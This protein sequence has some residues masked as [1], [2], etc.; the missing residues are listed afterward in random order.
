MNDLNF[1]LE[2]E[3]LEARIAKMTPEQLKAFDE[4]TAEYN[5]LPWLPQPGPQIDAFE[6]EADEMLYGGAAGGGKTDLIVGLSLTAHERTVV[7]R[8]QST[9]LEGLWER[10]V[11]VAEP[12]GKVA[13][14]NSVK[15]KMTTTDGR[16]IEMGHLEAPG[17]EKTWQGRPHDLI[18]FDEAAQLDE[19][20]ILFV[21]QWLRSTTPGQ[22]CR[23]MFATNPPIPEMEGGVFRDVGTGDWMKRW[24]APWIDPNYPNKAKPGELRWCIMRNVGDRQ[25]TLWVEG[26]GWYDPE[27]GQRWEDPTDEQQLAHGLAAAK[28][29]TFIKSLVENNIFLKGTGYAERLSAT[30]EP[31]RSMLRRGEFGLKLEDHP[32]QVIPTAWVAAAQERWYRRMEQID[33]DDKLR[34]ARMLV[35]AADI[36]QGGMDSTILVPLREDSLFDLPDIA[37][38]RDTPTGEE[39]VSRLLN[40]R[41]DG[42]MIVL[43]GTGGWGGSTRDLLKTHHKITARMHVSSA[44]STAWT[45][46]MRY[47]FL[48][49][50]SEMWWQFREDLDPESD[51]AICLPPSDALVSQ[52]TAPQWGLR[53]HTIVVESKDQLRKRLG[54]S[55]DEA[56]AVLMAWAMRATALAER[57]QIDPVA[58]A[59]GGWNPGVAEALSRA[60]EGQTEEFAD[61]LGDWNDF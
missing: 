29:R 6:H 25:E 18:A 39:V 30:P 26:P 42:A 7:F 53:G 49:L 47:D 59:H 35:L 9:D 16:L 8:R 45:K 4:A 10:L 31:L 38:G 57:H 51:H 27:T 11:E 40:L 32:M 56:D 36:A 48:N 44:K 46:D 19:A 21:T 22:R 41:K 13:S 14:Q 20:K 1:N 33:E 12:A 23:V 17:S 60:R 5:D 37:A 52:L 58:V 50:R 24:F 55:T 34:L 2:L 3:A 43:D 61:P 15:K 54:S 28:S